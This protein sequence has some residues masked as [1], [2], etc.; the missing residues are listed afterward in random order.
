M[1]CLG[2]TQKLIL[3]LLFICLTNISAASEKNSDLKYVDWQLLAFSELG[4]RYI[5]NSYFSTISTQENIWNQEIKE[6]GKFELGF[7]FKPQKKIKLKLEVEFD[8]N[9]PQPELNDFWMNLNLKS[10]QGVKIG[11]F[12]NQLGHYFNTSKKKRL[13]LNKTI[14]QQY[15]RTTLIMERDFG[16]EYRKSFSKNNEGLGL[17]LKGSVDGSKN[18]FVNPSL[19]YDGGFYALKSAYVGV[20]SER[21]EYGLRAYNQ[22]GVVSLGLNAGSVLG[23]LPKYQLISEVFAGDNVSSNIHNQILGAYEREYVFVLEQKQ[24]LAIGHD[25]R[26]LKASQYLLGV[27]MINPDS[28]NY[29]E[30]M[31]GVNLHMTESSSLIWKSELLWRFL[32][33]EGFTVASS[34]QFFL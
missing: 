30:G 11:Y 24:S 26:F 5:D 8:R 18:L 19:S 4:F 23:H 32:L 10:K 25:F 29:L 27:S 21:K 28:F 16:V 3:G 14:G 13:S 22:V 2:L 1:F 20:L 31:S 6:V 9:S 34:V 17:R 7:Q 15:V 12:K 33:Q